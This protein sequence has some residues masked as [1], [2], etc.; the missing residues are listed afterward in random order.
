MKIEIA[1][2]KSIINQEGTLTTPLFESYGP[3]TDLL[4]K[5]LL[6]AK[7]GKANAKMTK[8]MWVKAQKADPTINQ[9]I[10]L[11]KS[12]T[13]GHRKHHNNDCS[14]LKGMLREKNQLILRNGLLYRKM[15]NNRG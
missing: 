8:E 9:I 7:G 2:V 14:E 1:I 13:L 4:S 10:T 5:E 12:K 15:K 6:I 11:I 3:N